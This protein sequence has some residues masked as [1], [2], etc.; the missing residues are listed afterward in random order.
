[1]NEYELAREE[2]IRKNKEELLKLTKGLELPQART[3]APAGDACVAGA[4]SNT[5]LRRRHRPEGTV[6]RLG[7]SSTCPAFDLPELP[8][9]AAARDLR[10]IAPAHE[11]ATPR[12]RTDVGSWDSEAVARAP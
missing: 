7:P 12:C 3:V 10:P 8:S 1:M 9:T 2:R 6:E 4:G 11:R 5:T